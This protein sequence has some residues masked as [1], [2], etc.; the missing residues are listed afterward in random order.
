MLAGYHHFLDRLRS[1]GKLY[2]WCSC[3]RS[4]K[5]TKDM[6]LRMICFC[7]RRMIVMDKEDLPC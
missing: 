5:I 6:P 1:D 4:A 7:K 2:F 3:G